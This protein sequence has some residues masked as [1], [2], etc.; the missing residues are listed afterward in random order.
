MTEIDDEQITD[1]SLHRDADIYYAKA[2]Y[3][4]HLTPNMGLKSSFGYLHNDAEGKAETYDQYEVEL[5]YF[6]VH[7]AHTI[8]LTGSYA[9]RDYDGQNSIYGKTRSDNRS[10][11]FLAYEYANI[12]GLENWNLV[13]FAGV[14]YNDSNINFYSNEEYLASVGVSYKF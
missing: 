11:L 10:K 2:G 6:L 13:S 5:S 8:A 4:T 14:N 3:L 1:K 12:A 9:Y 7:N